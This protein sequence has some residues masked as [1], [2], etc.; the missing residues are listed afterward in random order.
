M[1]DVSISSVRERDE[2]YQG[3]PDIFAIDTEC[4]LLPE[5]SSTS[6]SESLPSMGSTV[7]SMYWKK[8]EWAAVTCDKLELLC[9]IRMVGLT[10]LLTQDHGQDGQR[11]IEGGEG[12][13]CVCRHL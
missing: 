6:N 2:H 8:L 11:V 4:T 1:D 7:N 3:L 10:S 9:R 12:G 13:R 5:D